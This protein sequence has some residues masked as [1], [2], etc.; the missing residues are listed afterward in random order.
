M[1]HDRHDQSQDPDHSEDQGEGA[2]QGK[3]LVHLGSFEFVARG[4]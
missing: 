1:D 4:A 2:D 3:G